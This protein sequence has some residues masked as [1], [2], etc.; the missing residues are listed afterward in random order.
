[1]NARTNAAAGLV[2]FIEQM[3]FPVLTYLRNAQ[4]YASAAEQGLSLFEMR[5]SLVKQD[6]EQWSPLLKWISDTTAIKV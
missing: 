5:P 1:V 4:V 6:L 3:G 2:D